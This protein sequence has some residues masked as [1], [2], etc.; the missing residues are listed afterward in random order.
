MP[1]LMSFALEHE[2]LT[3]ARVAKDPVRFPLSMYSALRW[4]IPVVMLRRV[5][6]VGLRNLRTPA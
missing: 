3:F 6:P 2:I 5:G 4:T 1:C